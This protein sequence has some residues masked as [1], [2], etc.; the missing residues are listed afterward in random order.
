MTEA[1]DGDDRSVDRTR[2]A[3]A[4]ADAQSPGAWIDAEGSRGEDRG[5]RA[6]AL[7]AQEALGAQGCLR[8]QEANKGQAE[9]GEVESWLCL[10]PYSDRPWALLEGIDM[11][12][13]QA[14]RVRH[15]RQLVVALR[16]ASVND[17]EGLWVE[18]L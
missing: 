2:A 5:G 7:R 11:V 14:R 17:L 8:L 16:H 18:L 13:T 9:P 10:L 1:N 15:F 3:G 6:A 4:G 12:G